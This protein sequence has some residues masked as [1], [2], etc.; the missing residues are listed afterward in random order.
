LSSSPSHVA[1]PE[2]TIATDNLRGAAWMLGGALFFSV[3][4][5][6]I[7]IAGQ[8]Q[9][10]FEI[11]FFRC[12]FGMLVVI[13][14]L[15]KSGLGAL[16]VKKPAL[17][18][19]RATCA[20][21]GMSGGF[22][23]MTHLELATA[24]SLSFTR[25]LF[26]I[27]LAAVF[28]REF[29]R[30]RRGLATAVGF[31]GVLIMVQPGTSSI[32]PAVLSGLLAALAVGGAL[33]TVKLIV[34]YDAPVTIMLTFSIATVVMAALPAAFVWQTPT[35]DE[36]LLLMGLGIVASCGQYCFIQAFAIGEATI[37]SPI[38]YVQIILGS[39]AGF[40]LFSERPGIE[41]FIGAAVIVA[42]TLYIVMRGAR[43]QAAPP[44][45]PDP[46]VTPPRA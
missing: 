44:P 4:A 36:L 35:T 25:P 23:A 13:P 43:V 29:V 24:I 45:P 46:A 39:A 32:E 21:I 6:L 27:I 18:L 41:T 31:I 2:H 16:K 8:T 15:M 9:H 5:V 42:S 3:T 14:L 37:M 40:F 10:T 17:H 26:M 11:V 22:Y 20:V 12:L 33:I 30:W 28:L 7:K 19:I 38:D 1:P 34:P